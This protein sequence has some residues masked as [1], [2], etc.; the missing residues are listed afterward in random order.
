MTRTCDTCG[1]DI[2][3]SASA[4]PHCG[5]AQG[6]AGA[7]AAARG[8][9][10]VNLEDGKPTVEQATRKLENAL[11]RAAVTGVA[12]LRVIH[13]YG[14]SGAGGRIREETRRYL[15]ALKQRGRLRDV[16]PGEDHGRRSPG[17]KRMLARCP[18]LERSLRT[19]AGNPG[20]TLIA[21]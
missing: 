15:A 3:A 8:V 6:Y 19:D 4:C 7:A 5:A 11:D 2:P 20:I 12:V 16:V 1:N 14:S 10:T 21:L 17:G 18:E 13:G 9:R